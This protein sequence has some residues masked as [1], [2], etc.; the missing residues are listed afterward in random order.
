MAGG[1][2]LAGL[3]LV[4]TMAY[5]LKKPVVVTR[6]SSGEQVRFLPLNRWGFYN[7]EDEMEPHLLTRWGILPHDDVVD[8]PNDPFALNLFTA[9]GCFDVCAPV[10]IIDPSLLPKPFVPS[11]H[12]KQWTVPK[13]PPPK[14]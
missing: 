6:L 11:A 3:F 9:Y 13:I 10:I 7:Q 14:P 2:A 4:V 12:G 8:E 1:V 5:N